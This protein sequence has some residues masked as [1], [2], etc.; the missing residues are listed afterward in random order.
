MPIFFYSNEL[1]VKGQSHGCHL[2][3]CGEKVPG[4]LQQP[5]LGI[6]RVVTQLAEHISTYLKGAFSQDFEVIFYLIISFYPY[7]I[8]SIFLLYIISVSKSSSN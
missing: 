3:V 6:H 7:R 1:T 8:V 4:V 2:L 5:S